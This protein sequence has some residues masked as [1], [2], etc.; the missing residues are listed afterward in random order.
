[1]ILDN[2]LEL[3]PEITHQLANNVANFDFNHNGLKPE[4]VHVASDYSP[5]L[6]IVAFKYQPYDLSTVNA[7]DN[8]LSTL[9]CYWIPTSEIPPQGSSVSVP[10]PSSLFVIFTFLFIVLFGRKN[11]F[12]CR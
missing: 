6:D 5:V 1:M 10:D 7:D 3:S 9:N 12:V 2:S 8:F 11:R 4:I